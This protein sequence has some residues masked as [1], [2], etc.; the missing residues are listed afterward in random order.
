VSFDERCQ[1]D[2][3]GKIAGD[4]IHRLKDPITGDVDMRDVLALCTRLCRCTAD[5][6]GLQHGLSQGQ[7]RQIYEEVGRRGPD[8][9]HNGFIVPLYA[10]SHMLHIA[11][12]EIQPL[13]APNGE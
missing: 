10:A 2:R 11:A 7:L 4:I 9:I 6:V 8:R 3:I 12:N 13:P 5:A 1:S